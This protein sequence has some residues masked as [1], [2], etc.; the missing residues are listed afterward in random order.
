MPD[1]APTATPDRASKRPL[2][3]W[4]GCALLAATALIHLVGYSA[5][6]GESAS[7]S[8]DAVAFFSLALRPL[9]LSVGLHWLFIAAI[10]V[11]TAK[12]V[13]RLS[14]R[15]VMACAVIILLDAAL[16]VA[17]LGFFGGETLLALSAVLLAIGASALTPKL[18]E[19][20]QT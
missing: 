17:F 3:L 11:L 19:R 14:R 18:A 7:E 16:L 1:G 12:S 13:S 15:I 4:T 2:V 20:P 5:I 6:S 8:G 10:C 9:W